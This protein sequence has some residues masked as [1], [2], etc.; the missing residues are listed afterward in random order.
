MPQ[1]VPHLWGIAKVE[2]RFFL[3]EMNVDNVCLSGWKHL[4]FFAK[5]CLQPGEK[6]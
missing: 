5:E 2:G 4:R 6:G 3:G 1:V